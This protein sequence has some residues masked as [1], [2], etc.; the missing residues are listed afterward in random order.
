MTS[1]IV[2]IPKIFRCDFTGAYFDKCIKCES[3]LMRG[4][5]PYIIEKALKPYG[6]YDS[7]STLFEYAMCMNCA[8]SMKTMMSKDSMAKLMEFFAQNMDLNKHRHQMNEAYPLQAYKWIEN[9]IVSGKAVSEVSECQIYAACVGDQLVFS[10][11][12]YMVAGSVLD[13]MVE[14]LSAETKDELDGFKDEYVDG[15]SEFQDLLQSGPKVF[16]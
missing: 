3:D 7:Y 13:Q 16:I 8:E 14:L 2:D 9:C 1:R 12:P 6:S 4:D 5:R 11:F 15:P 10:E